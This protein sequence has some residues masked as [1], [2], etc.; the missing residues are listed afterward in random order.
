[1]IPPSAND[2]PDMDSELFEQVTDDE[3]TLLDHYRS[4]QPEERA[5]VLETLVRMVE[6]VQKVRQGRRAGAKGHAAPAPR[7]SSDGERGLG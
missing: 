6:E 2:L 3:L 5:G 4:L 7:D 1:M